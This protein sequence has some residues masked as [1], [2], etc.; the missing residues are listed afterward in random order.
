MK[1]TLYYFDHAKMVGATGRRYS[2]DLC[3][4][5][6]PKHRS[7]EYRRS[8]APNRT[9]LEWLW[10][11]S[12]VFCI[13]T[14]TGFASS[15]CRAANQEPSADAKVIHVVLVGD[16][17][18]TPGAGWGNGFAASFDSHVQVTNLSRGGRSSKS[19]INEG[20]WKQALDLKPEY[21]LIQFGHN[22][23][24]VGDPTRGTDPQ[25]TYRQY[26]A[27]Y[28]DDARAAGIVPVLVTSLSRRQWGPDGKI[29]SK[30]TPY[31]EVVREHSRCLRSRMDETLNYGEPM[32]C[33]AVAP[34]S[35]R[36]PATIA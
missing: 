18:V 25:T 26:M 22:D 19:F 27:Q 1:N 24:K 30:L 6:R 4:R 33:Y 2:A 3:V 17:T 11:Y 28:I 34:R 13:V 10:L 29:H 35:R 14:L 32:P 7:A 5:N 16:S 9:T 31:A 15:P 23:Q 12:W 8:V 21:V 36:L 20:S